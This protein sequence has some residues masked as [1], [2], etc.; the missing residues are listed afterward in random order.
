MAELSPPVWKT[1]PT[2][3]RTLLEVIRAFRPIWS[4]SFPPAIEPANAPSSIEPEYP[5]SWVVFPISLIKYGMEATI[6]ITLRLYLWVASEERVK[7]NGGL[8]HTPPT[9]LYPNYP[10]RGGGKAIRTSKSKQVSK[11]IMRKQLQA[12]CFFFLPGIHLLTVS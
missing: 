2:K 5:R 8:I 6:A 4:A 3:K 11:H 7:V 12:T 10:G 9:L 1:L